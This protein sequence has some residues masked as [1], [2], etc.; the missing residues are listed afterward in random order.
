MGLRGLA[1]QRRVWMAHVRWSESGFEDFGLG[2]GGPWMQRRA[3]KGG[4]GSRDYLECR[5][6]F[7]GAKKVPQFILYKE[8]P[9]SCQEVKALFI[10]YFLFF[11]IFIFIFIFFKRGQMVEASICKQE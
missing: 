11:S 9:T 5:C 3:G 6:A 4:R 1:N 2:G 7:Q 10:F 8:L